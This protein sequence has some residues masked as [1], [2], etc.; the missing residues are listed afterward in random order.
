MS[1][2]KWVILKAMIWAVMVVPI[3]APMM[4][5][6]DCCRCINPA[7]TKPTTSTVVTDDDWMMAVTRAPATTPLKRLVVM[8][9]SRVFRR[10]PVLAFRALVSSSMPYRKMARP[11][12]RPMSMAPVSRDCS[13]GVNR[14]SSY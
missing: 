12:A 2:A 6:I 10:L 9:A 5:G 1:R 7:E 3:L 14:R 13:V 4:M 11:P 8:R